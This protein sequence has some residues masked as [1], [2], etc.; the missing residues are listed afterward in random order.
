MPHTMTALKYLTVVCLGLL[1][2][3]CSEFPSE[4]RFYEKTVNRE[5]VETILF[6]L[7]SNAFKY[8]PRGGEIE[9]GLKTTSSLNNSPTIELC[10]EDNGPGI[11]QD[12]INSHPSP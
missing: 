7:L 4:P 5:K 8:A 2:A 12:Q 11:D 10:V 3:G 9:I 1:L 6:N